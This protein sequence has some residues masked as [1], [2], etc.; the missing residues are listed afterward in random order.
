MYSSHDALPI[1]YTIIE[2]TSYIPKLNS[3]RSL[4]L[5]S[6]FDSFLFQ[7]LQFLPQKYPHGSKRPFRGEQHC[8]LILLVSE[9]LNFVYF[10]AGWPS[11]PAPVWY[12]KP[13]AETANLC[14]IYCCPHGMVMEAMVLDMFDNNHCSSSWFY[15]TWPLDCIV[16]D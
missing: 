15:F 12:S 1:T 3:P 4:I 2:P 11:N 13:F 14:T 8:T 6:L 10:K 5:D 16:L 9:I 7:H